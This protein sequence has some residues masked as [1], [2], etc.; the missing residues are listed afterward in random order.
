[1]VLFSIGDMM[2]TLAAATSFNTPF[3]P[4]ERFYT[5]LGHVHRAFSGNRL[6]DHVGL[7]AVNNKFVDE[8]EFGPSSLESF[9]LRNSLSAPILNMSA[10]AKRQLIDVLVQNSGFPETCFT[11]YNVD[12]YGPD[13]NVDLFLSLLIYAYYPNICHMELVFYVLT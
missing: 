7:L 10:E 3:V 1:M 2:C 12:L 6:S 9:C 11:K 4:R 13:A 8:A 5:K